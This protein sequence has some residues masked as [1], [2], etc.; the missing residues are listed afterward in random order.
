VLAQVSQV[1][2]QDR[3]GCDSRWPITRR[4]LGRKVLDG[5]HTKGHLLVA[6]LVITSMTAVAP[7]VAGTTWTR[8]QV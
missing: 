8:R 3:G 2:S 5:I 1:P 4:S 6:H 7:S